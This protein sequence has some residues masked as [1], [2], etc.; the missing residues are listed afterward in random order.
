[1]TNRFSISAMVNI[2]SRA[3]SVEGTVLCEIHP[4]SFHVLLF[5]L[6]G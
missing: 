2:P 3:D 4:F 5:L 6:L 1:M